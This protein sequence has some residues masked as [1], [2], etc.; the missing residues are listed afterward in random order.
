[1]DDF[2]VSK[3]LENKN[4]ALAFAIKTDYY[5]KQKFVVEIYS[6]QSLDIQVKPRAINLGISKIT[7]EKKFQK[8]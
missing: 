2:L 6:I 8:K 4:L 1:L 3:M 5:P 7:V